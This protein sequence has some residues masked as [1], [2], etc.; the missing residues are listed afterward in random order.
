MWITKPVD[1]RAADLLKCKF[2]WERKIMR[3]DKLFKNMGVIFSV[4]SLLSL[5][6][7]ILSTN[8]TDGE[9]WNMVVRGYNM[10]E[11]SP[12]GGVVVLTPVLLIGLMLSK[13]NNN[14]K[15]VGILTL[16]LFDGFATSSAYSAT[17]KWVFEQ[18]TG[19]IKSRQNQIIYFSLLVLAMICFYVDCN[20][21]RGRRISL[22][23]LFLKKELLAEPVEFSEQ[24]FFLCN[25]RCDFAK[26]KENGETVEGKNNICFANEEGYFTALNDDDNE[27]YCDIEPLGE[28]GAIGY[29]MG[30]MPTGIYGMFYEDF[31]FKNG[32]EIKIKEYPDIKNGNAQL[33][34]PDDNGE[35]KKEDISIKKLDVDDIRFKSKL[36]FEDAIIG[37]AVIQD[38]DLVAI[39]TDYNE[40]KQEYKCISAELM[41][42]DLCRMI[43]EHRVFIAMKN[44][45]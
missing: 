40:K 2:M 23:D 9:A 39:V 24:K 41:A 25:H 6:L 1:L 12:F 15:T 21:I 28:N 45:I 18:A 27:V 33:W 19:N 32:T 10:I 13:L 29:M 43:Y 14:L 4:V 35:F 7:P 31:D 37:S 17:Y 44:R 34:I 22:K 42:T 3:I 16:L 5:G 38:G 11:F 20:F 30:D 8:I 36:K 26:Y